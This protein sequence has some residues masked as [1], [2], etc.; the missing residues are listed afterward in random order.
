MWLIIR[1]LRANSP[2]SVG[3]IFSVARAYGTYT[4]RSPA[5]DDVERQR[6]VVAHDR[7]DDDVGVAAG[8]VDSAVAGG[9]RAEARLPRAHG[10]L[11]AP[12]H[13]LLVALASSPRRRPARRAPGNA[14]AR[15]R[16]RPSDHRKHRGGRAARP[17]PTASWRRRTRLSPRARSAPPRPE[18]GSFLRERAPARG[19]RPPRA[20]SPP[21][22]RRSRRTQRS[23]P[24]AR[25]GS[26]ARARWRS[27]PL[28]PPARRGRRR[29]ATA[30]ARESLDRRRRPPARMLVVAQATPSGG[31]HARDAS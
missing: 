7:V 17:P 25:A 26:P 18:R 28:S 5:L 13:A 3:T 29:S 16:S 2:P 11:V 14:P 10:H 24:V 4:A 21:C 23:P 19:P 30:T 22:H 27:S 20:R 9:D 1:R 8:R 6:Q 12:V 31:E 15:M